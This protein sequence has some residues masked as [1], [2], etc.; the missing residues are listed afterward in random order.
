M[1]Y[2]DWS[3]TASANVTVNG[4]NIAEGCPPGNTNNGLREIMAGVAQLNE[5]LPETDGFMTKVGGTFSGLQPR[6]ASSG[7]YLF[8]DDN[9]LTSGRISVLVD[10]SENPASPSAGDIVFFYAP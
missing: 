2:T 1:A 7:P 8:H 3:T 4:F 9:S 10:G 5:D 6:Y